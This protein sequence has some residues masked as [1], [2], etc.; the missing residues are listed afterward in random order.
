[1]A[2]V[3][4]TIIDSAPRPKISR[5]AAIT[6]KL[7][8]AAVITAPI[9]QMIANTSVEVLVPNRSTMTPPM[10]TMTTFGRL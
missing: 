2:T 8:D 5:P 1:M 6:G 3:I 7:G 10:S 4:A 9:A